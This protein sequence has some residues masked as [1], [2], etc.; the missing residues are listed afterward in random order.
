M[1]EINKSYKCNV[2][3]NVVKV[4]EAGIGELVCCGQ[5]MAI[6]EE[7][8]GVAP[9]VKPESNPAEGI[10]TPE[11]PPAESSANPVSESPTE[12]AVNTEE[13]PEENKPSF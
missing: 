8:A 6:I 5:P 9:E 2:C 10:A 11:T 13:K 1:A 4:T 7:Q 3:G 12:G